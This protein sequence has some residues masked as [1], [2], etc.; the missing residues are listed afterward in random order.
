MRSKTLFFLSFI[1]AVWIV[2][3]ATT[4]YAKFDSVGLGVVR[5][6]FTIPLLLGGLFVFGMSLV[7]WK[8]E[9]FVLRSFAFYALL[10]LFTSYLFL[11]LS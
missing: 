11:L 2:L 7:A 9:K 6:L 3:L 8:R 1:P 5:E 4:Y 10:I